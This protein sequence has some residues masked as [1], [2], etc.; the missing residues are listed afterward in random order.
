MD[1]GR[2]GEWTVENAMKTNPGKSKVVSFTRAWLEYPL[3]YFW[4]DQRILEVNSC[5][6]LGVILCSDLSWADQVNYTIQIAWK[7]IHFIMRILKK[8]NGDTKSLACMSLV[9]PF[10]ECGASCWDS[11]REGQINALDCMPKR[12]AKFANHKN[13]SVWEIMVQRR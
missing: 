8:G 3:N 2:L 1:L 5:K 10:L 4:G 7:T 6:H 12:A 11:H 9:R 13:H